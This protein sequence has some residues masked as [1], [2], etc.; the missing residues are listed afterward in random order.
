MTVIW[1]IPKP[2]IVTKSS[3]KIK[4]EIKQIYR[5]RVKT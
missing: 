5:S 3:K 2:K 4:Q 1:N